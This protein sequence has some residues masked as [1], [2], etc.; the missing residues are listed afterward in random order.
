[1]KMT[2]IGFVLLLPV[3]GRSGTGEAIGGTSQPTTAVAVSEGWLQLPARELVLDVQHGYL[4]YGARRDAGEFMT[5]VLNVLLAAN[6]NVR[7]SDEFIQGEIGYYR[8]H[9]NQELPVEMSAAILS[10][11]ESARASRVLDWSCFKR[12][13]TAE[14][15][16]AERHLPWLS[17][18]Y[19]AKAIGLAGSESTN[20]A[21]LH[22]LL[23]W[24]GRIYGGGM[25]HSRRPGSLPGEV[26]LT[27]GQK[28]LWAFAAEMRLTR[29]SQTLFEKT[30]PRE[31]W[32]QS[33]IT[34]YDQPLWKT[35][36]AVLQ[37]LATGLRPKPQPA[38]QI[39]SAKSRKHTHTAAERN[40][41]Q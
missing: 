37:D 41:A 16:G 2:L 28:Q 19:K 33:Y 13:T 4:E 25:Q 3:M 11:L 10:C 39:D 5:G 24:K 30:Y 32:Q 20:L 29:G 34:I 38:G 40:S 8:A 1:M 6:Y 14:P 27:E 15:T 35:S 7:L 36:Q 23:N 22:L 31:E 26:V 18:P 12:S 21:C 17:P 9:P